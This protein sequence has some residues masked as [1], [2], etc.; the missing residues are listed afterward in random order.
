MRRRRGEEGLTATQLAVVMP[1]VIFLIMLIV[2]YGLWAHAKQVASA[3]AAEGVDAGQV[4]GAAPAAAE[5]AA[6]SFLAGAG[7]LDDIAVTVV[8]GDDS[9]TVRV[10][11]Q[12]PRLVPGISWNVAAVAEA[13]LEQFVP[14]NE[15]PR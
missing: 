14:E 15:R 6:R 3:A 1:A 11:G 7:N 9:V 4:P 13:P 10:D 5:Q 2:Q 12:A 8:T